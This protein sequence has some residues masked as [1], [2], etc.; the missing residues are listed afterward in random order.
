[1]TTNNKKYST[2]FINSIIE[3]LEIE[4]FELKKDKKIK[5]IVTKYKK[6]I[7]LG[8]NILVR[9]KIKKINKHTIKISV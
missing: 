3:A 4:K 5:K 6:T 1:M 9:K 7:F 2:H 8:R